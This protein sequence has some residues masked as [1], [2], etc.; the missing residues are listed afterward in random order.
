MKIKVNEGQ[1]HV[2]SVPLQLN[3]RFCIFIYNFRSSDA[4]LHFIVLLQQS[5]I[6][7]LQQSVLALQTYDMN[8]VWYLSA[9]L[10]APAMSN[11]L[12]HFLE[13][14]WLDIILK[15]VVAN[16]N[17]VRVPRTH[18]ERHDRTRLG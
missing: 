8:A 5:S 16:H 1:T 4:I 3:V 15:Y 10:V 12:S 17:S 13:S 2:Q 6:V 11:V 9:K 7:L 14:K 18:G